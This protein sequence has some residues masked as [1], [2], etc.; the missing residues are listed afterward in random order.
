MNTT[1]LE[2]VRGLMRRRQL[3]Q[4]I[5]TQPQ[6]I[7]YLAGEW[8]APM[9][10]LDALIITGDDVRMLCY[11]L[12]V[13][14]PE[15]C[16]TVIY[17]DMGRALPCLMELMERVPTG[18]DGGMAARFCLPLIEAM[19][20][21]RFTASDCV[22]AARMIKDADEIERLIYASELTDRVFRDSFAR[23]EAGMSERELA[24]VFC[25]RFEAEGAGVFPGLPMVAFGANSAE[26]HAST[27]TYRLRPGDAIMVDTGMRI[28]GYYSDTTRTAFL[29]SASDRQRRVYDTVLRANEAAIAAARPGALLSD[30]DRAA[31]EVISRAGLGEFFTH[32]TSHGV[33]IDFHELPTDRDDCA[34]VLEPGMAFSIEPGV[35]LPGEFGVRIEDLAIVTFSGNIIA[36]HCDKQILVI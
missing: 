7:Y 23:I 36:T 14:E 10:R 31:R 3:E 20:E 35:Y 27:G 19:P 13:I 33:G 22:D 32:K 21:V 2:R 9:D 18:I 1:R 6:S 5:I 30:V 28:N 16:K 12:A 17:S 24:R 34:V 25:E 8:V 26:P 4:L 15:N 11:N 29:G